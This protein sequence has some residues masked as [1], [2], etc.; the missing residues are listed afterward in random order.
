MKTLLFATCYLHRQPDAARYEKWIDFYRARAGQL[1]VDALVLIDDGSHPDL[2]PRVAPVLHAERLPEKLDAPVSFVTFDSQLGR[3][4]VDEHVGWMRSFTFSHVLVQRYGFTKVI[5]VE[6]DFFLLTDPVLQ[7][8]RDTRRGWSSFWS[9]LYAWPESAIQI[10]CEDRL[11]DLQYLYDKV[12][13]CQY[14]PAE[15]AE[16]LIPISKVVHSFRGDRVEAPLQL[17]GAATPAPPADYAG[18]VPIH[19]NPHAYAARYEFPR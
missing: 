6:S 7:F 15:I 19:E 2:F 11:E 14:N 4:T 3:P 10:I 13:S 16:I 1:G 12:R 18:Q 5:H 9:K 17:R 8:I